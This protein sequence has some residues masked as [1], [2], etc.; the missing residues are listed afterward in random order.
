MSKVDDLISRGAVQISR[1]YRRVY[2]A[3]PNCVK[4]L[5]EHYPERYDSL[6]ES[7]LARL[8]SE[9]LN[10]VWH[11][12]QTENTPANAENTAELTP[13]EFDEF[14]EKMTGKKPWSFEGKEAC[15]HCSSYGHMHRRDCPN[16]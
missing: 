6:V 12:S 14:R 13:S 3:P 10:S 5:K 4:Y 2:M 15:E 7:M 9:A 16:G 8:E 1:K 11:L